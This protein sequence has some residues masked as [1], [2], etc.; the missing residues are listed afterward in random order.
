LTS[1][2]VGAGGCS[3]DAVFW[4]DDEAGAAAVLAGSFRLQPELKHEAAIRLPAMNV[5]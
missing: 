2:K 3:T 4:V 5:R 1:F